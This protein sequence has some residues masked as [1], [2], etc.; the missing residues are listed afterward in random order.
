MLPR[1]EIGGISLPTYWLMFAVGF[2]SIVVLMQYRRKQYSLTTVQAIFFSLLIT[3]FGLT[4]TK[5]LAVIQNWD[6]VQERGL[7]A[8]GQSFFGAVFLLPVGMA[9]CARLF[10]MR[11]LAAVDASAPCIA[12]MIGFMRVGCFLNGCCGGWEAELFGLRFRWPTQAMESIGDFFV[13]GL[14][15][16]TEEQNR[17]AGKRYAMFLIGYGIVRFFVEFLRNT[18]KGLLGLGDGQWFAVLGILIG[19]VVLLRNAGTNNRKQKRNV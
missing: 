7:S 18:E 5:L 17:N 19:A 14:L 12:S 9:L 4:G 3:L 6:E 13:L 8:A 1:L 2:L 16:Q 15:L 11:S 10:R